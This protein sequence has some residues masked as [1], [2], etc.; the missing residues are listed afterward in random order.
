MPTLPTTQLSHFIYSF[1]LELQKAF[2]YFL[3]PPH[4]QYNSPRL[5]LLSIITFKTQ[6]GSNRMCD[7]VTASASRPGQMEQPG[8][9]YTTAG[10]FGR[11]A[12]SHVPRKES[13]KMMERS[14]FFWETRSSW[15][16]GILENIWS[17]GPSRAALT[18]VCTVCVCGWVYRKCA[19]MPSLCLLFKKRMTCE[20]VWEKKSVWGH[21]M[22]FGSIFFFSPLI[23]IPETKPK[24]SCLLHPSL[25]FPPLSLSFLFPHP[26]QNCSFYEAS[27]LKPL[28]LSP[29][30]SLVCFCSF[31]PPSTSSPHAAPF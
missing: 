9:A 30:V 24:T 8:Y 2:Y 14:H 25:S 20:N 26:L 12:S 29:Q 22:G 23:S 19:L 17:S 6:T 1:P 27:V 15:A 28:L 13:E 7:K 16:S 21:F 10:C 4:F 5:C 18:C 3:F 31:L 11:G